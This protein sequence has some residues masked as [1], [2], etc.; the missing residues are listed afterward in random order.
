[1]KTTATAIRAICNNRLP[2]F[3]GIDVVDGFHQ[4]AVVVLVVLDEHEQ[5]LQG[6]LCYLRR[7]QLQ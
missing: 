2:T 1:M 7:L 6:S 3:T 5:Q 4:E